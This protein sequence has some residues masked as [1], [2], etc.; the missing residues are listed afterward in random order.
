MAS[1]IFGDMYVES[2]LP[3]LLAWMCFIF[4]GGDGK[5]LFVSSSS[6]LSTISALCDATEYSKTRQTLFSC[7]VEVDNIA[8]DVAGE[9]C[10]A[11]D[12]NSS[13]CFSSCC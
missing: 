4:F 9:S 10:V 3:L 7:F 8:N 5:S 2:G 11:I 13:S 6:C 1:F 12:P